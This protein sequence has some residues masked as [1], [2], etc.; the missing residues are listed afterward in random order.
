MELKKKQRASE[1]LKEEYPEL[2]VPFWMH[3]W[4]S[5]SSGMYITSRGK[6]SRARRRSGKVSGL[7]LSSRLGNNSRSYRKISDTL[8]GRVRKM[9]VDRETQGKITCT[10]I[11]IEVF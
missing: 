5:R 11:G 10:R 1:A 9:V 8:F 3:S 4:N 7:F 6:Y 2:E